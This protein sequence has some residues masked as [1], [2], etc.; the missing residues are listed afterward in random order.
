ML[1]KGLLRCLAYQ[2]RSQDRS[3]RGGQADHVDRTAHQTS[4]NQRS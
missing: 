1:V 3:L 4:K 2:L